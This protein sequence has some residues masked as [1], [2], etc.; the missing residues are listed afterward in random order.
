M[1]EGV[2]PED[3][4]YNIYGI[5]NILSEP[6]INGKQVKCIKIIDSKKAIKD[7][8]KDNKKLKCNTNT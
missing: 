3:C 7:V 5:C 4:E 6:F 2:K 8:R 1:C